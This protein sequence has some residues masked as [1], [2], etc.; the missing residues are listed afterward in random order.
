MLSG[1]NDMK[2]FEGILICTD[3]DGTLLLSDGTVSKEN[4]EAIEYFKENGGMFTIISGR[5]PITARKICALVKPNVPFGCINGGGLYDVSKGEFVWINTLPEEGLELVEYVDR[6]MPDMGIQ[7]NTPEVLYFSKDNSA[8][9]A[10][11]RL[12]D[13]PNLVRHYREVEPPISKI[14]FAHEDEEEMFR[15]IKLLDEHPKSHKFS[16][17]RSEKYLYE[18]LPKGTDKSM[19]LSKLVEILG[20][21]VKKTVAIGD[22]YND[23]GM[24]KYAGVGISVANGCDEI[25]AVADHITVS[26]DEHAIAKVIE[27]IEKGVIA[28]G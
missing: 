17:V 1:E 15:L 26:N 5:V 8:M 9:E 12:V 21:D 16:F 4:L 20:L 28:L 19:A 14:L 10:F 24:V 25:R 7:V 3:L 11:R 23:I 2:K 22:Y 27:D 18:L 13:V 6:M